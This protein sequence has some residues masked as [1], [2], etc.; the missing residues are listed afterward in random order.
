[1][2]GVRRRQSAQAREALQTLLVDRRDCTRVLVAGTS[3]DAFTGDATFGRL[4]AAS[5]WPTTFG[6]PNG[7]Q[8]RV[9]SW[10]RFR[11]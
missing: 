10:L 11:Q 6:R 3:G 1:M 9:W 8:T 4:L 5:S 2:R 7:L